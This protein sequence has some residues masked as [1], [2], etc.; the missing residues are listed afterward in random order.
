MME[1]RHIQGERTMNKTLYIVLVTMIV[2]SMSA[3]AETT[4]LSDTFNRTDGA[5][6]SSEIPNDE[7][8]LY[9][10]SA[11][12]FNI[13][14]KVLNV[15]WTGNDA[16]ML[17]TN[18]TAHIES[19]VFRTVIKAVNVST[20]SYV[21]AGF[22]VNCKS[23]YD[24]YANGLCD[25]LI[26]F[27]EGSTTL[28][29][30]DSEWN[31]NFY[32]NTDIDFREQK[33]W[34]EIAFDT[35]TPS[36]SL[37]RMKVWDDDFNGNLILDTGIIEFS[38]VSND[39]YKMA[40][41]EIVGGST[42]YL[43]MDSIVID[44]NVSNLLTPL[45]TLCSDFNQTGETILNNNIMMTEDCNLTYGIKINASNLMIDLGG[46]DFNAQVDGVS[47][48]STGQSLDNITIRNGTLRG[49]DYDLGVINI[50][51]QTHSNITIEY[52]DSYSS[53]KIYNTHNVTLAYNIVHDFYESWETEVYTGMGI[54]VDDSY[55][56]W[57]HD[58]EV[59]NL[60]N[61]SYTNTNPFQYNK[62]YAI[63]VN[64]T[65]GG[66]A[67]IEN[68]HIENISFHGIGV[69]YQEDVEIR[70]NTLQETFGIDI[71]TT[72][73]V[74][75]NNITGL[76]PSFDS[77]V[78]IILGN[79][80]NSTVE[81]NILNGTMTG[82]NIRDA[83]YILAYN[84]TVDLQYQNSSTTTLP[85]GKGIW[86]FGTSH[87]CDIQD[88]TILNHSDVFDVG[89][90]AY[91]EASA[92]NNTVTYN[93]FHYDSEVSGNT[94][95]NSVYNNTF[96]N[97]NILP[98]MVSSA[99]TPLHPLSNETLIMECKGEDGDG[100][101][102]IYDWKV[103]KNDTV[104][105]S[106]T[107]DSVTHN[108]TINPV[109]ISL[110]NTSL[111]DVF[112]FECQVNDSLNQSDKMNSSVANIDFFY[113]DFNRLNG[114]SY[115]AIVGNGWVE[116]STPLSS[117]AETNLWLDGSLEVLEISDLIT[118]SS[119]YTSIHYDLRNDTFMTS[120]KMRISH[121]YNEGLNIKALDS[122]LTDFIHIG[123]RNISSISSMVYYDES[124]ISHTFFDNYTHGVYYRLEVR[125]INYTTN[126]Y[127]IWVNDEFKTQASFRN[128]VDEGIRF[129]MDSKGITTPQ[130][131]FIDEVRISYNTPYNPVIPNYFTALNDVSTIQSEIFNNDTFQ[132]SVNA[133]DENDDN[134][135]YNCSIYR[136][137][138]DT[139]TSES[140]V[141]YLDAVG[142]PEGTIVQFNYTS[143][144]INVDYR[145]GYFARCNASDDNY[146]T[147]NQDTSRVHVF[148][149]LPVVQT[150]ELY[151]AISSDLD[152]QHGYC[153]VTDADGYLIDYHYRIYLYN[154]TEWILHWNDVILDVSSGTRQLMFN[155]TSMYRQLGYHDTPYIMEC[156]GV[157]SLNEG[158][159][160]NS[161]QIV[162]RNDI[163]VI[164]NIWTV[165]EFPIRNESA[166]W[167]MN[168]SDINVD[169]GDIIWEVKRD[170]TI[171]DSGEVSHAYPYEYMM[172]SQNISVILLTPE[173]TYLGGNYSIS[174]RVNDGYDITEYE[175]DEFYITVPF[176]EL[177][178]AFYIGDMLGETGAGLGEFSNQATSNGGIPKFLFMLL[179]IG[180]LISI[181][182]TIGKKISSSI[183][184]GFK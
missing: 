46:Y 90:V 162:I 165:P 150:S 43:E 98:L 76:S 124:N 75:H 131:Y 11:S 35:S 139:N 64:S 85:S 108:V 7:W 160:L 81:W 178:G 128:E 83:D 96:V 168:F 69:A 175:Y 120:F 23:T 72:A 4:Y 91:I 127:D 153:N 155:T 143:L 41:L 10:K 176:M 78:G 33:S 80:E 40:G 12:E 157:D 9:G 66:D 100:D 173:Q 171:F 97:S 86:L 138:Y 122:N 8:E 169:T 73:Y 49:S 47:L 16:I 58:N 44:S 1:H 34:I 146:T 24:A 14:D 172:K 182:V 116:Y 19:G 56:I 74:H 112:I 133:T 111:W 104:F 29:M 141:G 151:P 37:I 130:R 82:I 38:T 167:Y 68:N 52:I 161:T 174:V 54:S 95:N 110:L 48:F 71:Q 55:D 109:N 50:G 67:L 136:H 99:I 26:Y 148:N 114:G 88:N 62:V 65:S 156:F 101:D 177:N 181:V 166:R 79:H 21:H 60:G 27:D 77:N 31:D 32:T 89:S 125:N 15:T 92:Y 30:Y 103:Y 25:F 102:L 129:Y 84:N 42:D 183:Q 45:H 106:G 59:Y 13:T 119:K 113:D 121:E 142:V 149:R 123:F 145:V 137:D 51:N 18:Q 126:T 61:L 70:Y 144:D 147:E 163:S 107:T 184:G 3:L 159:R 28:S 140:L 152:Y 117:L 2:M 6:G 158:D 22:Q 57:I 170:G 164:G 36:D 154:G 93:I 118:N 17:A 132:F 94:E 115:I 39:T 20:S 179:I 53:I 63:I 180:V 135:I 105:D 134:L 87:D 5:I